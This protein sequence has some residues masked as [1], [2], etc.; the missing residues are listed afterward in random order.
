MAIIAVLDLVYNCSFL[1]IRCWPLTYPRAIFKG[2]TFT[3]SLA[4]DLCALALTTERYL[5]LCW[6]QQMRNMSPT[7]TRI[8]RGLGGLVVTVI[9]MCRMQHAIVDMEKI[10]PFPPEVK[11]LWEPAHVGV[12]IFSDMILPFIL[13][14]LMIGLSGKIIHVVVKRKRNRVKVIPEGSTGGTRFTSVHKGGV[15]DDG[16]E[17]G[18]AG[19]G[20]SAQ[21]AAKGGAKNQAD[22]GSSV[23]SLVL[24]LDFFF[25]LNQVGYNFFAVADVIDT[26]CEKCEAGE[27]LYYDATFQSDF[28]ECL[29]RALHFYFYMAFSRL[30]RKEFLAFVGRTRKCRC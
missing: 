4:S 24:V 30:L 19:G 16:L 9:S 29:S 2:I 15:E 7:V 20:P 3:C 17:E 23:I 14:V 11:A 25:I 21:K 18:G 22:D 13:M 10:K 12:S 6:P 5:V 27:K 28:V 26:M 8:V 1:Y